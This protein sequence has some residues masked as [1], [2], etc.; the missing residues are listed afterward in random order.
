MLSKAKMHLVQS[1]STSNIYLLHLLCS[2]DTADSLNAVLMMQEGRIVFQ[3]I[4]VM[5]P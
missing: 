5:L 1:S 3:L 2:L 4:C